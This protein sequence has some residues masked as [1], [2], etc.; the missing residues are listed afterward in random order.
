MQGAS[1]T[2]RRWRP[3]AT[4]HTQSG[5]MAGFRLA[6]TKS[7]QACFPSEGAEGAG[8]VL[9]AEQAARLVE[10]KGGAASWESWGTVPAL[11]PTQWDSRSPREAHSCRGPGQLVE[12]PPR[13]SS[14]AHG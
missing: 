10:W 12:P 5:F 11:A 6:G 1:G 4:P 14:N 2:T 3:A 13:L 8:R 9:R 7:C